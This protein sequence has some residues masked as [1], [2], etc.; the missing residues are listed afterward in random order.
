MHCSY[1][2][3]PSSASAL[4]T[5]VQ[6]QLSI[7]QIRSSQMRTQRCRHARAFQNLRQGFCIGSGT[8][9]LLCPSCCAVNECSSTAEEHAQLAQSFLTEN[10][11]MKIVRAEQVYSSQGNHKT[12]S[13]TSQEIAFVLEGME[14][15]G[16]LRRVSFRLDK[17]RCTVA[18]PRR[19]H[20]ERRQP[21]AQHAQPLGPPDPNLKGLS[22]T[23]RRVEAS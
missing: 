23:L 14:R 4:A 21:T 8:G 9:A 22:C 7:P 2:R 10:T 3:V 6:F 19:L 5:G 16:R 1:A 11:Y 15:R 13:P 18:V 17:L 20:H 12:T